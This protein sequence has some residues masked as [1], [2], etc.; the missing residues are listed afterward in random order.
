MAPGLCPGEPHII[1]KDP[2]SHPGKGTPSFFRVKR[3]K[4]VPSYSVSPSL[5]VCTWAGGEGSTGKGSS[6]ALCTHCPTAPLHAPPQPRLCSVLLPQSAPGQGHTLR[7]DSGKPS[8]RWIYP[9]PAKPSP[10]PDGQNP[11]RFQGSAPPHR[12]HRR[13]K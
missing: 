13:G 5:R 1:H 3:P 7:A 10:R 9:T 8:Q 6:R 4:L 2:Y 11:A 12:F